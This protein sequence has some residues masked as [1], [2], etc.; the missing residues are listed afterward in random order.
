MLHHQRQPVND[1]V[2]KT[3]DHQ[4]QQARGK[5]QEWCRGFKQLQ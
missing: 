4:P 2:Q 3:A 5:Q 1:N